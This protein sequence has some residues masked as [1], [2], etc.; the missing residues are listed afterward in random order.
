MQKPSAFKRQF[1]VM[2]FA[3]H[4]TQLFLRRYFQHL[5]TKKNNFTYQSQK[6]FSYETGLFSKITIVLKVKVNL[7]TLCYPNHLISPDMKSGLLC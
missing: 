3:F 7:T 6:R 2:T 4:L 1:T 5:F